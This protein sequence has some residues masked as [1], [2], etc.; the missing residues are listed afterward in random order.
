MTAVFLV[1][2]NGRVASSFFSST[3]D[4][5]AARAGRR[6]VGRGE[7]AGRVGGLGLVDV[8]VVEEAGAELDPQDPA[9]R[10]VEPA[11]GDPVLRRAAASP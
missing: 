1:G 8:R 9:H 4:L 2:S 7:E 3:I 6:A 11:H 10:V 5:P